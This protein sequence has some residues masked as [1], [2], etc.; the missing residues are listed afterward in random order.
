[1]SRRRRLLTASLRISV[2]F[3]EEARGIVSG[4]RGEARHSFMDAKGSFGLSGDGAS[5]LGRRWLP[6]DV[7]KSLHGGV[8]EL[9]PWRLPSLGEPSDGFADAPVVG[10]GIECVVAHLEGWRLCPLLADGLDFGA[11]EAVKGMF[12][13][14]ADDVGGGGPQS[15]GRVGPV[16]VPFEAS[17]LGRVVG[18]DRPP[19]KDW[20]AG[21][22]DE[23]AFV[24]LGA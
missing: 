21:S 1:M 13:E 24:F 18:A 15:D 12:G 23:W 7:F 2:H 19:S 16:C 20:G 14:V 5:P 11:D 17:F 6:V 9:L 8:E 4:G 3:M 10:V 22:A